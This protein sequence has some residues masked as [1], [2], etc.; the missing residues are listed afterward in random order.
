MT[1]EQEKELKRNY[2]KSLP[3]KQLALKHCIDKSDAMTMLSLLHKLAGSAGMYGFQEISD[4]AKELEQCL[5]VSLV[6]ESEEI[7]E[8]YSQLVSI[9]NDVKE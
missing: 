6:I 5:N 3:D 7:K 2:R 1:S 9:M 4:Q 8:K